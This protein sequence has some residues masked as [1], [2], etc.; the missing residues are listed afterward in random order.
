[1]RLL[2]ILFFFKEMSPINMLHLKLLF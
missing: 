2:D 1:M